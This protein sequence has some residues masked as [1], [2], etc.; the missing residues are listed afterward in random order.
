MI[1][2]AI[3][4]LVEPIA[5]LTDALAM[6]QVTVFAQAT[7]DLASAADSI[8]DLTANVKFR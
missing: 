2:R 7:H 6:S 1:S 3:K 5:L 4:T 8:V